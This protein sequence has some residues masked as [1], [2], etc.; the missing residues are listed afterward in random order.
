MRRATMNWPTFW[1][2]LFTGIA[3]G[4]IA[5]KFAMIIG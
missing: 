1:L 3:L 4:M 2:T 5:I